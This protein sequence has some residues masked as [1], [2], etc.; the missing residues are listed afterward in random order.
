MSIKKNDFI[1]IEFTGKIKNTGEVFDTNRKQDAKS[2]NLKEDKIKPFILSVGNKMLPEGFD[3]D[4]LGKEIGKE[5]DL[6]LKPEKAFGKRNPQLV[7]MIPLKAFTEQK[8]QPQRG[9]QLNLDGKIAKVLSTSG[10]R[11]L[12]DMNNP[13]AGK[14]VQYNYKILNKIEDEKKQIE[15]MQDFLFRKQFEYNLD[16]DKKEITFKVPQPMVQ[17]MEMMSKPFE[18]TLGL[19][20]KAEAVEEKSEKE[21]PK[22]DKKE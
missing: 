6:E 13:L 2:L 16:K 11:V 22:E 18:D 7:Q 17:Y 10:G 20:A 15:A 3:E 5:Y 1:E 21:K 14:E 19:K 9:M 4:F 12:V 8:I